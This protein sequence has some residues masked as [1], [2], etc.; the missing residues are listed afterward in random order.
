[1]KRERVHCLR[2]FIFVEQTPA[3]QAI[4]RSVIAVDVVCAGVPAVT[5]HIRD[6]YLAARAVS[7]GVAVL[8]AL[9]YV[10]A[11]AR[12]VEAIFAVEF[13]AVRRGL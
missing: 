7:V 11:D 3:E 4:R 13:G 1:M 6:A 8:P 2:S 12:A 10:R 5:V 9:S